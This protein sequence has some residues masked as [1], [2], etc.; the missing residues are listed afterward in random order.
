MIS[1]NSGCGGAALHRREFGET[2]RR[3]NTSFP[4]WFCDAFT[5]YNQRVDALPVDQHQ[6]IALVAPRACYV[7]SAVED[8]WADPKGE[9]LSLL[10]AAPAYRR[11]GQQTSPPEQHPAVDQPWSEGPL[12]YHV[13]S[14]KHDVTE[15]DWRQYL[16]FADRTWGR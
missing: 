7:A 4:H 9:Y 1:N 14:G 10:H 15:F 11:L 13:R 16:E 5:T 12:G 2:V 8:R 6:L 3:I